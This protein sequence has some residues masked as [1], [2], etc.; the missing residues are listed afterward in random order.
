MKV[1]DR[2][3]KRAAAHE[4]HHVKRPAIVIN[5]KIVNR[6]DAGVL[7]LASDLHFAEESL[8]GGSVI[9]NQALQRHLASDVGILAAQTSPMPPRT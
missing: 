8:F 4:L 7:K 6:H 3:L 2:C 9:T 1:L 5:A